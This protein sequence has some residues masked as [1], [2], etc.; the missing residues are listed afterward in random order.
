M[1][2]SLEWAVHEIKKIQ[3]AARNGQ[4]I[5]KPRWPVLILR[6]PKVSR[7]SSHRFLL[8]RAT[9]ELPYVEKLNYT[10]A[11]TLS[12]YLFFSSTSRVGQVPNNS[13]VNT[14]R[15]PSTLTKSP[16]QMQRMT[17]KN[18]M[19]FNIGL[20]HTTLARSSTRLP[21]S[22]TMQSFVS[23]PILPPSA[24]A[25]ARRPMVTTSPSRHR[26]GKHLVLKKEPRRAA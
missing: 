25:S 1:A 14:S 2:A 3:S 26:I 11:N 9:R 17:R 23:Y 19:P 18:L 15:V 7:A 24:L 10:F 12:P 20:T 13:M 22:P 8:F 5:V 4:P 16:F 21:V 6:T